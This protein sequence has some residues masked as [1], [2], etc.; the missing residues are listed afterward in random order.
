MCLSGHNL[1]DM[2]IKVDTRNLVVGAFHLMASKVTK[3]K[4]I[5][6]SKLS[7]KHL[8]LKYHLVGV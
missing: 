5:V 7:G 2:V 1:G 4:Y 8:V 6:K 3:R